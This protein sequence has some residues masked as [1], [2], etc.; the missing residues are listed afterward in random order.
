MP[1]L[2]RFSFLTLFFLISGFFF[3]VVFYSLFRHPSHFHDKV[4]FPLNGFFGRGNP[5]VDNPSIVPFSVNVSNKELAGLKDRLTKCRIGHEQLEDVHDFEYG[6]PIGELM[7]WRDRWMNEYDWREAEKKLNAMGDHFR[8]QIEG[9]QIHFIRSRPADPSVYKRVVPILLCHG[10]P[11]NVFEFHKL[12]PLLTSPR[13]NSIRNI[14]SS[15]VAFEVIIPSIPGYGWSEQPHKRGFN[16]MATARIF[17]KLMVE[18][19]GFRRYIAQ[20]GDWGSMVS[21]NM[22][23]MFPESVAGLHLNVVFPD[24]KSPSQLL[25]SLFGSL[26]PRWIFSGPEGPTYSLAGIFSFIFRESG[27]MHIQATKPD[28][29]GVALN[30]SPLGL[31]AYILEKFVCWTNPSFLKLADGGLG[32]KFTRDDLLT[33]VSIYWFNGNILSSQR[34][35]KEHFASDSNTEKLYRKYVAVPTAYAAF[36]YDLGGVLPREMV[37]RQYNLTQMT[38]FE[39]GGHFAAFECPKELGEDI[40]RFAQGLSLD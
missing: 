1:L 30:D 19:L 35:Y 9:L 28:T 18:R 38:L 6:F 26:A 17:H 11:G 5:F 2:N 10:W 23:R 4:D 3:A 27:Y 40:I 34:Y 15:E 20:G 36:P 8:T 31:L 33:I 13:S 14:S 37:S 24:F 32:K 21:S 25:I 16:Q 29:V 12:V 7:E 22:A 39:D